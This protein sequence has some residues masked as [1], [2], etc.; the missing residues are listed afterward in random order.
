MSDP[1]RIS[2]DFD[3][4]CRTPTGCR[5]IYGHVGNG[6]E[7]GFCQGQIAPN[8]RAGKFN[9]PPYCEAHTALCVETPRRSNML[10]F[11]RWRNDH[12]YGSIDHDVMPCSPN[13]GDFPELPVDLA[14]ALNR[15]GEFQRD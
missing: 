15:T 9:A 2:S 8:G 14:I 7:W 13:R 11:M 10:R 3:D 4:P 1:A 12:G 6:D 5:Y